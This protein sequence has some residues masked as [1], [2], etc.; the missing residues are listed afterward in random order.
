MN[1]RL[2]QPK[3]DQC[4]NCYAYKQKNIDDQSYNSHIT[5]K[6]EARKEKERDK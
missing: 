1:I 3:E 2:C 6:N 5:M 4:T